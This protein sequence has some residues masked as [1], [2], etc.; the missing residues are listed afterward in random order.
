MK[1]ESLIN[2]PEYTQKFALEKFICYF[3][4][5]TRE[6]MRT[7]SDQE[8]TS[9]Q[10]NQII[11]AYKSYVID[12]KPI[13]YVLWF[14][15]FFGTK[16]HVNGDTLIPRPETEYMITAVTEFCQNKFP[17]DKEG[18]GG[19]N[20]EQGRLKYLP[21]DTSLT[22]RAK[23]LRANM[24]IAEKKLRY[25]FLREHKYKF[26]R[27]RPIDRYIADFY[28]SELWLVIEI[29]WDT[30]SSDEA[31]LYD[32]KRTK[33]LE[34]LWLKVIRFTNEEVIWNFDWVCGEIERQIWT[35]P[36][37]PCQGSG[38]DSI[39]LDVWTGCGV[40]WCSVLMQNPDVFKT[41]FLSDY[42]QE[43][44]IVAKQNYDKLI[45]ASKYDTYFIYSD[46]V[47]YLENYKNLVQNK[48]IVLVANLPYIPEKTHDDNNPESVKKRE[49]RMAF[50]WWDDGLIYYRRMFNQIFQYKK[51][52]IITGEVTMFLEMMTRQVE[53]LVE[54]FGEKIQFEEV[55]TFHFNIRILKAILR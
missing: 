6:D 1:I 3:L 47:A 40:L 8:L 54:E 52:W 51:D 29:D 39:L 18:E 17:P 34:E 25:D 24:T 15:E 28:C 2:N 14:V 5:L 16:F 49:P 23:K 37:S 10:E 36:T 26:N 53:L 35:P 12:K 21:Y 43:A 4:G 27:Q 33:D 19:S 20:E 9:D 41:V 45:D 7:Q 55:K 42:S 32:E 46:L 50:V 31:K 44:L 48:D 30:H 22:E 11:T 13:E 38:N